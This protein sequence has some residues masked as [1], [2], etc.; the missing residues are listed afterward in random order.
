[1]RIFYIIT[2]SFLIL[3]SCSKNPS[4]LDSGEGQI[5]MRIALKTASAGSPL[6]KSLADSIELTRVRFLIRHVKFKSIDED[7]L[8]Y[9]THPKVVDIP[10]DGNSAKIEDST[11]PYGTYD[12]VEFRI[13]RLDDDDPTDLSYFNHPDFAEFVQ[14]NR[15]SIIIEGTTDGKGFVFRSRE[16]ATQKHFINPAIDVNDTDNN[17]EVTLVMDKS[18]WF[19]DDQG[20]FLNPADESNEDEISDNIKNSIKVE[21]GF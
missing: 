14:D 19:I 7:S 11:V 2:L 21:Y 1:M 4:Q 13:H 20:G 3:W 6:V 15:Y 9:A 16:N 18:G 12:R 5:S 8:E 10:L 17:V